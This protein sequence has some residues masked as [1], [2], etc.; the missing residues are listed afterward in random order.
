MESTRKIWSRAP[1]TA[2][3]T[4][5][6]AAALL[7]ACGGEKTTGQRYACTDSTGNVVDDRYCDDERTYGGYFYRS[8]P[9]GSGYTQPAVGSRLT[10]TPIAA[11]NP[12]ARTSAGLPATGK[13]SGKTV[14]VS[15]KSGGLGKSGNASTS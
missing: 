3:I 6:M 1:R 5:A 10:S 11:N 2:V 14:T 7:G 13:A 15:G 8:Y 4:T 9:Y 12:S